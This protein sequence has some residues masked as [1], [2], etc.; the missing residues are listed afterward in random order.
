MPEEGEDR[1]F[2]ISDLREDIPN[3][4]GCDLDLVNKGF[5]VVT[6]LTLDQ[7]DYDALET[8]GE[9]LKLLGR[10]TYR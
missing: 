7:T 10:H 2:F 9:D 4:A 3:E 8:V 5:I 1:A 6:P